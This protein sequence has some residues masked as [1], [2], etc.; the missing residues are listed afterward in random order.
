MNKPKYTPGSVI[1]PWRLIEFLGSGGNAEVWLAEGSLGICALKILKTRNRDSEPYRRFRTEIEVMNRLGVREGVVP[2]I[3]SQLPESGKEPAWLAMPRATLIRAALGNQPTLCEVVAAIQRIARIL[4][5]LADQG[6]VHRDIKPENLYQHEGNWCVGDFGLVD[7]PEKAEFTVEGRLFGPMHYHAPEC[8]KGVGGKPA[9]VYSLAKTLWVLATG[10]TYPLPGHLDTGTDAYLLSTYCPGEGIRP[11]ELLIH[12]STQ[13]DPA[14]RPTMQ[15]FASE[16]A[17]WL[18]PAQVLTQMKSDADLKNTVQSI[19]GPLRQAARDR[20]RR[21]DRC[22]FL[23]ETAEKTLKDSVLPILT[24]NGIAFHQGSYDIKAKIHDWI[25]IEQMASLRCGGAVFSAEETIYRGMETCRVNLA[26]AV[27]IAVSPEGETTIVGLM[28]L[29]EVA[30]KT[31]TIWNDKT[32]AVTESALELS[33]LTRVIDGMKR[34]LP[35]GIRA[36]MQRC[37]TVARAR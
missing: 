32:T 28:V 3:A 20:V 30:E 29:S 34:A 17:A 5:Q 15:E 9:D 8:L 25:G 37:D 7:Y 4:A 18:S 13:H 1:E 33:Q 22:N 21:A 11:L 31:E 12:R 36:F 10:Q 6:I 35:T 27:L 2:I 23:I 16:L 26:L 24:E 19:T 14:K